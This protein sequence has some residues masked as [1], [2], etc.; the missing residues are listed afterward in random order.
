MGKTTTFLLFLELQSL[1]E[2]CRSLL[3]HSN[4]F[5]ISLLFLLV[6]QIVR[7]ISVDKL[8]C[9]AAMS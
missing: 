6:L 9:E 5:G 7:G 2:N 3:L 4:V 8:H 1:I